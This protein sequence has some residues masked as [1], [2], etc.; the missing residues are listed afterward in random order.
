MQEADAVHL[1]QEQAGV[2]RIR[3]I[4]AVDFEMDG[5]CFSGSSELV[6]VVVDKYRDDVSFSSIFLILLRQEFGEVTFQ[7]EQFV[8][9]T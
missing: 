8:C 7:S 5:C 4:A 9:E 3:W 6:I 2:Q 1:S